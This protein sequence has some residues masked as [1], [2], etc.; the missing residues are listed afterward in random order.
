MGRLSSYTVTRGLHFITVLFITQFAMASGSTPRPHIRDSA[1]IL[2]ARCTSS[3]DD[4]TAEV[5]YAIRTTRHSGLAETL[6]SKPVNVRVLV[7]GR[8]TNEA[9]IVQP[10]TLRSV[11]PIVFIDVGPPPLERHLP[12]TAQ[13]NA[14]A[15]SVR[16]WVQT[17]A[18]QRRDWDYRFIAGDE[19][20][21]KISG[22]VA[23]DR[24]AKDPDAA[25]KSVGELPYERLDA[26]IE[27]FRTEPRLL[28][29]VAEAAP[30]WLPRETTEWATY[31][32][33]DAAERRRQGHEEQARVAR[34]D[35]DAD[36]LDF[37]AED[38]FV[39]LATG[40]EPSPP[41][42]TAGTPRPKLAIT[43]PAAL[44]RASSD[45]ATPAER[46]KL[47]AALREGV[48]TLTKADPQLMNPR[49]FLDR[50]AAL[51][52]VEYR[53]RALVPLPE[54]A[55]PS[56]GSYNIRVQ[57][58]HGTTP[59]IAT[60][61]SPI[62]EPAVPNW[63]RV[64]LR[65]IKTVSWWLTIGALILV[66]IATVL[67]RGKP[68]GDTAEVARNALFAIAGVLF[69]IALTIAVD[70]DSTLK[71]HVALTAARLGSLLILF[72]TGYWFLFRE[73]A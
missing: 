62:L 61:E 37:F 49:F 2:S 34:H 72:A 35:V 19:R 5:D 30:I 51:D 54:I 16:A 6:I 59:L 4:C 7:S 27:S 60:N 63:T 69:G 48:R 25:W 70:A 52:I 53:G 40:T 36:S 17:V 28:V 26:M 18:G 33:L 21:C 66:F 73:K 46:M 56:S 24:L 50:V 57:L 8:G 3:Q 68:S 44:A 32:N 13:T 29:V 31:G 65:G 43:D 64:A 67:Q 9:T 38:G 1:S 15:P 20:I 58:L 11:R 39:L 23:A 45:A 47:R 71:Q 55:R 41:P 10:M 12:V 22:S 42:T 14:L